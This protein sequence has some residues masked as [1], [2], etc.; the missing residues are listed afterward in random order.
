MKKIPILLAIATLFLFPSISTAK[1]ISFL[2]IDVNSYL[3]SKAIKGIQIPDNIHIKFFTYHDITRDSS[4]REFIGA[5]EVIVVDVMM[6]ELSKY[7]ID[8][9]DIGEK[10]VYALR[11][12]RDDEGLKRKGFIFDPDISEYF[13]NLSVSNIRN[14][15]YRVAHKE[16]DPSLTFKPVERLPVPGIYHTGAEKVFTGYEEYLKWYKSGHQYMEG[17]P[18][19]GVMLFSSSLIDGQVETVD[20]LI[21]RLEHGGFNVVAAYGRDLEVLT[22][23]LMDKNGRPGVDLVLAFSLKFY[24][25]MN[26]EMRSALIKLDVPIFDAINLYSNTVDEWRN[27][28]IGIPPMDVVWTI[29]NPEISGLIEPTPLTGKVK[30][31]D[32]DTGRGLF[33]H[34]PV[35]ENIDQFILRLKMWVQ[36]KNRDNRKKRIAILYYNHS[37]GKQN[38]GASYLNVFRSLE[39]I[40]GRMKN[41]G[42]RVKMDK[43]ISEDAIKELVLRYGRNIGSWAPGVLDRMLKERKVIRL[44]VSTYDKWFEKLPEDFRKNVIKQWG[45]AKDSS[46]MTKKGEFIIPAVILDNVLLMPEPSRGWGDSPMKLYHDPTLY[47]HHQYIAAY[48][49]LKLGFHADAMIHLGTHAT[50]EWLPGKQAGLSPSCPPE[51]LITDIPNIYPYIVDDVGEGIQ[52]KRR[53]RGVIIDHLTPAV[54]EGGLYHEYSRLYDMISG[55]NRAVS[56]GSRTASGKLKKIEDLVTKLGIHKD[57]GITEY[58]EDTLDEIEHYLLE[59]RENLMPYGLHTFGISP[60]GEALE[61]TIKAIVKRNSQ[62]GEEDVKNGLLTSGAREIDHLIKGLEGG[63]IPAGEGNDPIRNV[64]AIPTGKNFFGFNPDKIPSPAAWDLGRQAAE[65]IIQKSLK[66]KGRYPEKVAIVLW[67]TETIRNEGIN[68]STILFLMGLRPKWDK[69]GRVTGTEVISGKKLGRPR[70]DVLINPSGL[71]RDLFPNMILFL[72]RAV[73]KAAVLTDIENLILKHNARIKDRLLKSGM[74]EE[75]ADILSKI[76]IFTERPG[77]YG[78]GVAEMTGNSGFWESDDE[79]VKVYENR[80]GYAFGLGKWGEDAKETLRE[81]LKEVDVAVHSISSNIYGTMDNDDMFQYLGGLS[82]AVKKESGQTPDTLI[83]MQR[84]PDQIGVEDVARTIGRELRTRYLNP[85]WIEGM[86]KEKYAGAREMSKFVEY[87]WG[88][89]VT[90][91][92]AIDRAKW[93]QTYEVYVEDK[94]GMDLKE[95]FNGEN[96]WAYQSI[97]ARMLEAVRKA[98]WQADDKIKRKLSVEYAINVVEKGVACCDHT[99]NNPFLN[100]MVVNIISLPGVMSPEMVER[101]KLAI[102]Q[103]MGKALAEQVKARKELQKKLTEGFTGKKLSGEQKKS[104]PSSKKEISKEGMEPEMVEG[105]KME[106]VKAKDETTDLTSSGVQWFASLFVLLIIGLF[107]YGVKRRAKPR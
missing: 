56:L 25:A 31:Q 4:A 94:Y 37:Q 57:L 64:G 66:E 26:H 74:D 54:K 52:A 51:V 11:G 98:Y 42:Y 28:P 70:I 61:D 76:R 5:S 107:V 34:K 91:P 59:L 24:S 2:V 36:L 63:Y 80:V 16:F 29:A 7:L 86:K 20:Y 15:I 6:S 72:D 105:Y 85:E 83:T 47:P 87:M 67:A 3:V 43:R 97:T 103:A 75:R 33:V 30:F 79:I 22:S 41:K 19:I 93:E 35:K 82:L 13:S 8:N 50:H 101:F 90:T 100:Q 84:I 39:L 45:K 68:E 23:L 1:Q 69:S 32:P 9:V 48:L 77:S 95:F 78:T 38:V 58:G 102:E 89:Q 14:L 88:W 99:C 44:P 49:W 12:S 73:Q 62:A 60:D 65:Q 106:E 81:N 40:L 104:S 55:Y 17:R 71:Y 10:R 21:K 92:K 96:P 46:I 27:D 53:G 18:W